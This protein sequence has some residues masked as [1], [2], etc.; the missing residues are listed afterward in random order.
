MDI[1]IPYYED[2]TRISNSN[3]GWFLKKGPRY[4]KEMLDGKEGLKA[5]FLDKGTM[6]HE[7]ILQPEEFWKDYIIL[8]FAVPKVKQQKDLLEF[9]SSARLVDPFASEDDILLM[10]YEAAYNNTKSKEKKIQEAKELVELYQN[11][12][13][14]FRNKDSKKVISFADLNMLKAIKKNM[15][16]HKKANELLFNYPETFEVHNEFHI[17]WEYPNASSLGDLPCKSLLDRVM[18]DHTNKKII[19]VDIKTTADVYNFKHSIEEFDYCRQLAYYWLAIHWYFK[20]ELKLNIEEYE[21]ETYI[22]AVQ[23]HDGYE[24][25]VFKFNHKTIEERLVIIDY[26]IKRI[27]WHKDNNLWDHMKEYYDEDGAEIIC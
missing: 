3:I 19:L 20:N 17:N 13:E 21:Y 15:E 4:L 10:S 8:D 1:S 12:I 25:R 22:V 16:E 11:Y 23:S 24:V 9:Y 5:S 14:Y 7:Y 26:A 27:A 2:L 6:I 18:I